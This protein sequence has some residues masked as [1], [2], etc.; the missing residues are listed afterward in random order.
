MDSRKDNLDSLLVLLGEAHESGVF[1]DQTNRFPWKAKVPVAQSGGHRRH[2]WI[3]L[4]SPLAAA[5][6]VAVLF[7]GPNLFS[8]RSNSVSHV[9]VPVEIRSQEPELL[10]D[11]AAV[12]S[13][14]AVVECDFN[15]DG[16]VDGLDIQA[17]AD[18]RQQVAGDPDA[19]RQ[20]LL[21]A[22][23]LTRCMLEGS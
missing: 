20:L 18:R 5:A 16:R 19:E 4:G 11:N 6:A 10:A 8:G 2:Q 15:G 9:N 14:S 22:D 3:W 21:M 1:D 13:A 17:F 7:V 12:S 23:Q